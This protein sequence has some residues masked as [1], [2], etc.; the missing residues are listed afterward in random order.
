MVQKNKEKTGDTKS[1]RKVSRVKPA[2]DYKPPKRVRRVNAVKPDLMEKLSETLKIAELAPI[3]NR[4]HP[5]TVVPD[6]EKSSGGGV[7][8]RRNCRPEEFETGTHIADAFQDVFAS[9]NHE[10][11][12]TGLAA[13][14]VAESALEKV[15]LFEELAASATKEYWQARRKLLLV[16]KI[17]NSTYKSI[18]TEEAEAIQ[19]LTKEDI[20]VVLKKVMETELSAA[21]TNNK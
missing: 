6:F 18:E 1:R 12:I 20:A 7:F 10:S 3:L 2:T 13:Y 19:K 11:S 9:S 16:N 21:H 8:R 17:L 5:K 4:E 14:L 15:Q